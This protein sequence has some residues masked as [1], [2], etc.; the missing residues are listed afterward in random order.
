M[1]KIM[2]ASASPRRQELLKLIGLE[3]QVMPSNAEEIIDESDTA[4]ET[5]LRLSYI[6]ARDVKEKAKDYIVI[7]ADTIVVYNN[8]IL[9]KPLDE[10]DAYRMLSLLNGK[11]HYVLTGFTVIG[12]EKVISKYEE[13][14]VTFRQL[15]EKEIKAYIMTKEPFD[16]AGSYAIQGIG[17]VMIE[18]INGDYF[19]IVGLPVCKLSN[20]LLKEF[21]IKIL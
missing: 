3:F 14:A 7:G 1:K 4:S 5:V 20:V 16:K 9:G 2:L 10:Q 6:K 11:T 21:G 12:E 8:E 19:N 13:S 15:S 17:S 18:K